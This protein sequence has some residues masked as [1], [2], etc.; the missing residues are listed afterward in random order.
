MPDLEENRIFYNQILL[1]LTNKGL[2]KLREVY[3]TFEEE[4]PTIYFDNQFDDAKEILKQ[5]ANEIESIISELN[6]FQAR[7]N[8]ENNF[9]TIKHTENIDSIIS[10]VKNNLQ[11]SNT[12]NLGKQF[13]QFI[14]YPLV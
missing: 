4:P 13:I 2:I 12:T 7:R 11:K 1:E 5:E 10:D 14:E 6:H 9:R 3:K 8:Y